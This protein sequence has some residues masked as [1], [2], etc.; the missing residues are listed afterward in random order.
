MLTSRRTGIIACLVALPLLLVSID[1][2]TQR[3]GRPTA[4][5]HYV[6]APDASYSY[7]LVETTKREGAT[8]HRLEMT[9]QTWRTE[10]EVDRPEWVHWL[11]IIRPETVR[12]TTGL[13]FIG[14]GSNDGKPPRIDA[15]LA[16]VAVATES[17]VA[18]LRMVP[19]QP[20]T[21][22]GQEKGLYEDALIA[23]TWDQ[24]LRGG[25][26]Q[27]PARFPMTKSAVR[28]MDTVSAFASTTEG[29][30]VSVERFVV[31]GASKR[32]W[33]A[34]TTA[35]T[36][37]RVVAVI[38]IVIDLLNID[39]SF[40]H[41][42]RAYGFWAPA[43]KDYEDV[44]I[45]AWRGTP[46]FQALMK[47]VEPYEYRDRLTIPKFIINSTGDQFFLPDSS[48]FY[49]RDLKGEKYLRYVPNTD[50]SLRDS[51]ALASLT[52]YYQALLENTPRPR[53]RWS[54]A[55]NGSIRVRTTDRP[56]EVKLWQATNPKAR[57][58]RL[59]T[60]GAAY[61]STPLEDR[62]NGTYIA[63]VQRPASGWT[64]FFVE[65]TYPT[66]GPH[67][68]KFT[69][70]VHVLPDRLPYPPPKPGSIPTRTTE[71]AMPGAPR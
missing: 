21:F 50:H 65:L 62:G 32:G 13:L 24:F 6:H 46:R 53:F 71:P 9:S 11:T 16:R 70:D 26:D 68:L 42:W 10:A 29:G 47:L 43:V 20:L 36:D 58:F 55:N 28:A 61:T 14:G 40:T 17:V 64:A 45:M 51:D 5:D 54:A 44:D 59:E 66:A 69:T 52:A 22:A 49:F 37:R 25:D 1:A 63:R 18:E 8:I 57:D 60:I 12:H 30:N 4:L 35:A 2:R 27:W 15:G 7:E 67:P 34:W 31:S 33:T 39:P 23:Y 41:H 19:N 3:P 38:P 48:Q 56:A